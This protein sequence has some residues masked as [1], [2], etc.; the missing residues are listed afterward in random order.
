MYKAMALLLTI[1]TAIATGTGVAW[2]KVFCF[3]CA[4]A[5]F[6]FWRSNV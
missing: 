4:V 3:S 2:Q 1:G 6:A 5:F